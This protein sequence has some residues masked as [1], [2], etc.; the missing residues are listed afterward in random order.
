MELDASKRSEAVLQDQ[1]ST[2]HDVFKVVGGPLAHTR[3]LL[4]HVAGQHVSSAG[5]RP[6]TLHCTGMPQ[7]TAACQT[8]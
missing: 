4:G 1:L 6:I 2:A 8:G 3:V 7:H 5:P